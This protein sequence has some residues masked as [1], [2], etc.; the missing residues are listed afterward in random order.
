MWAW[1]RAQVFPWVLSMGLYIKS[2]KR[3][4]ACGFTLS[5]HV[6]RHDYHINRAR[7]VNKS[8][9]PTPPSML[10]AGEGVT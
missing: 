6:E 2:S 10:R 8:S 3:K 1:S 4:R 9:P 5:K 7:C